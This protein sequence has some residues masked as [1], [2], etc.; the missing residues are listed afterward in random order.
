MAE[1]HPVLPRITSEKSEKV[2]ATM[3]ES[4]SEPGTCTG[5]CVLP[6]DAVNSARVRPLLSAQHPSG[7]IQSE[8]LYNDAT[9]SDAWMT[10]AGCI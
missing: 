3:F 2:S 10:N 6:A 1:P 7:A 8:S 4:P 9:T 5:D